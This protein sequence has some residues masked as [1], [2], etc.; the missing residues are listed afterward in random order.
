MLSSASLAMLELDINTTK[1]HKD[2]LNNKGPRIVEPQTK[3][4]GTRFD[5]CSCFCWTS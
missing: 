1:S 2:M 3:F 4:P 5:F